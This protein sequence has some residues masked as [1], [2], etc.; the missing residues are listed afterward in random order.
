MQPLRDY[1]FID[2]ARLNSYFEKVS[3]S[4]ITYD[5]VLSWKGG[6][7]VTTFGAEGSQVMHGRPF[8][9]S[10]K[11]EKLLGFLRKGDSFLEGCDSIIDYV[12]LFGGIT[13]SHSLDTSYSLE[14]LE[15]Y[16]KS[17]SL[18]IEEHISSKEFHLAEIEVVKI[19]LPLSEQKIQEEVILW[20]GSVRSSRIL[21]KPKEWTNSFCYDLPVILLQNFSRDD[22]KPEGRKG[23][24]SP[25]HDLTQEFSKSFIH[26]SVNFDDQA[27]LKEE[28]CHQL[29]RSIIGWQKS[30]IHRNA[31]LNRMGAVV[32][33]PRKIYALYRLRK[34]VYNEF[35]P[36][37]EQRGIGEF[38]AYPIFIAAA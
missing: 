22:E 21:N 33:F 36:E 7:G 23:M 27:F 34:F 4:P 37:W 6:I 3:L 29:I 1:L 19:T 35:P 10:E 15:L 8:T 32:D 26:T 38:Y 12:S 30:G 18:G 25:Y 13:D 28:Q 17:K 2:H 11:I 16:R 14:E 31:I 20:V 5:K 24:G 9:I